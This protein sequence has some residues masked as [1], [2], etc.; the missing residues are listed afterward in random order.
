MVTTLRKYHKT[1][2]M[3]AASVVGDSPLFVLEYLMRFLRVAVLLSVWRILLTGKGTVSGM[4]LSSVLTYTL[5]AE[6]C[7]EQMNCRTWLEDSFWSGMITTRF[8]RPMGLFGQ[9]AAEMFGW[10]AFHFA[11]FSVPLLLCAPLLGVNP[12]PA[13]RAAAGLFFV[14]LALAVLVGLALEYIFSALALVLEIHPYAINSARAAVA[15][16]LSGAFIPLALL[17]WGIG[18]VFAWLPFAAT[19]SAPLQ[20]YTGT[21]NASKLIAL[22][23]AWAALLWPAARLL[24]DRTRERMIAHGG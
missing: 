3:A 24:W 16:L 11:A 7:A 21:G 6:V 22:Q 15:T 14:S 12:L 13:G 19:A 10:W 17:P 9:F 1:A 4:T 18:G 8:V 2:A 20:I 23:A 5:I